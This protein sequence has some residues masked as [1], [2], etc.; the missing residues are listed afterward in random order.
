MSA[1]ANTRKFPAGARQ[2]T[3]A[4][5]AEMCARPAGPPFCCLTAEIGAGL[6][7]AGTA[8][9]GCTLEA[10]LGSPIAASRL[11]D[12]IAA[13]T[14]CEA[15]LTRIPSAADRPRYRL[16]VPRGRDADLVI[17]QARLTGPDGQPL[18]GMPSTVAAGR[19]CDC[20]AS[21]RGAFLAAGTL[22]DPLQWHPGL[23]VACPT[24]ESAY[25]L[26]A[27]ARRAGIGTAQV[28]DSRGGWTVTVQDARAGG[29]QVSE[30][31]RLI[32]C[33]V[34]AGKWLDRRQQDGAATGEQSGT[35][36]EQGCAPVGFSRLNETRA[37]R[38]GARTAI[39][40]AVALEILG[41]GAPAHLAEAGRL[42]IEHPAVTFTQ[43]GQLAD[44]P[45]GKH[46]IAGR[47]RRLIF[48]AEAMA[49]AA[50]MA[51]SGQEPAAAVSDRRPV[52][53]PAAH[54]AHTASCRAQR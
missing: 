50:A 47:V 11:R 51:R 33:P 23:S 38:A 53:S 6:R 5:V 7:T 34:T 1:A 43:L 29:T 18:A 36:G 28:R 42:R 52:S 26:A 9:I 12:A 21:W 30:L 31:L 35:A 3:D 41:A 48:L 19:R 13:L 45:L 37:A 15:H 39:R 20:T 4:A 32:G 25:A 24:L 27:A 54:S 8:Q 17:R 44:P 14:S 40:A 16:Y 2:W 10:V 22:R 49:A 46:A